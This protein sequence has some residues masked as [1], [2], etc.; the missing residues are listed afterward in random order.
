MTIESLYIASTGMSV[1]DKNIQVISNNLANINTPG[2][3]KFE[4]ASSDLAYTT[5]KSSG[6]SEAEGAEPRP[7]GVSIGS[8]AKV[9]GTYR[10]TKQ[11][12][13]TATNNA[14]DVA[15]QGP[16]YFQVIA[17]G[18]S[19]YTRAGNFKIS[20]DRVVTTSEGYP[21][22]PKLEISADIDL[23][24]VT[25]GQDGKVSYVDNNGQQGTLEPIQ[26]FKFSNEQGLDPIGSNLF[27]QTTASGEAQ[28]VILGVMQ[29]ATLNQK[30]LERSG[31]DPVEELSSLIT[32]QRAYE[33]NSKVIKIVDGLLESVNGLK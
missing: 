11:M 3:Q 20:P 7:V 12:P 15:I 13:S 28:A 26:I 9:A 19:A 1:A 24:R 22:S 16:G 31:V 8:G 6:T 5:I 14:L 30:Q 21:L 27:I 2:F 17:N 4:L 23:N 33:L 29:E 10:I 18:K 25:I 32:A